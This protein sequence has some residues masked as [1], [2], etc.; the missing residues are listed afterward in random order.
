MHFIGEERFWGFDSRPYGDVY[1]ES[2]QPDPISTAPEHALT[3]PGPAE[4]SEEQM[5]ETIVTKLGTSFLSEYKGDQ[6]FCLFLSYNRPHFP[7][8]PPKRLW[9][10]YFPEAADLP[11]AFD[12]ESLHPWMRHH[13]KYFG[14]DRMTEEE[15]RAC[16]A[17]SRA[18]VEL[19]DEQVRTVMGVLEASPF[20]KN[21]IVIYMSDHGDNFGEHGLWRKSTCYEEAMK[22]PL[23]F[24][25]PSVIPTGKR[26]KVPVQ[27]VDL[28]P[29]V[30]SLTN[31]SFAPESN[32]NAVPLDG[33]SLL[34]SNGDVID[35]KTT[36][37][38]IG[39]YYSH[40]VPGPMRMIRRGDWKYCMYL[41][42]RPSLFN[43]NDDPY[44]MNDLAGDGNIAAKLCRELEEILRSDWDER[45]A[46]SSYVYSP[47]SNYRQVDPSVR[48]SPN[49]YLT[50][51]G[52]YVDAEDF[53][54]NVDWGRVPDL[55]LPG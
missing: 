26:V 7:L 39:E 33:R 51:N 35:G 3:P 9:D 6:P 10:K 18:C 11:A 13:R 55:N 45:L 25:Y 41:G 36:S 46:R 27:L 30:L 28:L 4:I 52:D 44:E 54:S 50:V 2:H 5:Q 8:R 15:T 20:A 32:Y 53:Y 49:Q 23:I 38:I 16:R 12:L 24:S 34:N 22:V 14:V 40:G 43:L 48:R 29:T 1:G 17:G 42:A 47:T 21:T 31:T 19:I 37:S